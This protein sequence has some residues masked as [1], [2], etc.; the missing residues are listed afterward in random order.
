MF[1][2]YLHHPLSPIHKTFCSCTNFQLT[3]LILRPMYV[4][5]TSRS[6]KALAWFLRASTIDSVVMIVGSF[7]GGGVI[8]FKAEIFRSA[9]LTYSWRRSNSS[10]DDHK[11]NFVFNC[12]FSLLRHWI[13]LLWDTFSQEIFY[14]FFRLSILINLPATQKT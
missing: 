8:S 6:L 3:P 10:I 2:I 11:L 12:H 13:E 7:N 4:D 1:A 9:L 14:W 5:V